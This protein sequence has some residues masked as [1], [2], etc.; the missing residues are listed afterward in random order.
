MPA[1]LLAPAT[2]H[3][4]PAIASMRHCDNAALRQCAVLRCAALLNAAPRCATLQAALE[5]QQLKLLDGRRQVQ[6]ALHPPPPEKPYDTGL[7]NAMGTSPLRVS[8]FSKADMLARKHMLPSQPPPPPLEKHAGGSAAAGMMPGDVTASGSTAGD[9]QTAPGHGQGQA[10]SR[11]TRR[12]QSVFVGGSGSGGGGG[13]GG[14]GGALLGG[15]LPDPYAKEAALPTS[16]SHAGLIQRSTTTSYAARL[17]H[18][19]SPPPT[20]DAAASATASAAASAVASAASASSLQ[21]SLQAARAGTPAPPQPATTTNALSGFRASRGWGGGAGHKAA[22]PGRG[23][24]GGG[25]GG[26][27]AR[28]SSKPGDAAKTPGETVLAA[29]DDIWEDLC[30]TL[31][32]L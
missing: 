30:S 18:S 16:A 7:A 23:G 4:P 29:A 15:S 9:G 24:G 5:E 20:T 31:R 2:R 8:M 21:A 12:S 32:D 3:P 11:R 1:P 13:G 17:L 26:G 22:K 28:A 10:A 25:G 19:T 14:G 27:R 6:R